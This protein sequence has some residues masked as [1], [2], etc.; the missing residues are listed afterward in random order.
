MKKIKGYK[1]FITEELMAD[2]PP[3]AP[4][5]IHA[6]YQVPVDKY[7]SEDTYTFD[8]GDTLHKVT[9]SKSEMLKMTKYQHWTLDSTQVNTIYDTII[10]QNPDT[11]VTQHTFKFNV[12][13]DNFQTAKYQLSEDQISDINSA[14]DSILS[15]RG[16]ITDFQIESSTDKEPIQMEYNGKKSNEALAQRRA[17]AVSNELTE[18][19]I[20]QSIITQTIKPEQGPDIYSTT[21]SKEERDSARMETKDYRYV[22]INI[23]YI[24]SNIEILPQIT[25]IIP[26]EKHIYFLSKPTDTN[27]HYRFK[28]SHKKKST[29]IKNTKRVKN[30]KGNNSTKCF[31]LNDQ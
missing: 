5:E 1:Q 6:P 2:L 8:P 12:D 20:D 18:M 30:N 29:S 4:T 24:S 11:V 28:N 25:Q 7:S 13:G 17:D 3:K 15:E 22:T 10:K 27:K 14:I 23:I 16:I 26:K 21:M 9:K 19:G 31:F